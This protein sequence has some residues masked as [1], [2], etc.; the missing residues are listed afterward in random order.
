MAYLIKKSK[1][2]NEIIYMEYDLHGYKFNP[3]PS[4]TK[5][6]YINVKEVTLINPEMIDSVLS[7]KFNHVFNKLFNR[8]VE[9]INDEDSTEDDTMMV[10][11]EVELLRG[12]LLNKYQSFLK[13]EKEQLFLKK[14][15][16]LDNELKVK[17]MMIRER[18]LALENELEMAKGKSL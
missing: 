5:E 16:L 11:G 1:N 4:N 12:I 3:K 8:V 17:L 10:L 15:T 6:A 18:K 2:S 13:M 7:I 14:L 9:V